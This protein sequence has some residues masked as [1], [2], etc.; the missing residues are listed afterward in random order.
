[1]QEVEVKGRHLGNARLDPDKITFEFTVYE[2]A[3]TLRLDDENN[4][5]WW[6][7]I[8]ISKDQLEKLLQQMKVGPLG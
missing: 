6:L 3:V 1:M 8:T 2:D 4:L 5:A 7:E